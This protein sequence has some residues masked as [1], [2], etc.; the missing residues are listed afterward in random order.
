VLAPV[1][2]A[3]GRVVPNAVRL[4]TRRD[5]IERQ[6]EL[7]KAILRDHL[8]C[9]AAIAIVLAVQLIFG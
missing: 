3:G 5:P 4:G 8:V 7:A 1:A 6:S 9:A 2:L